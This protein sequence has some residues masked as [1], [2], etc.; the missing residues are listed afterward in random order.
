MPIQQ[1]TPRD[2]RAILREQQKCIVLY[3]MYCCHSHLS[4]FLLNNFAISIS[5]IFSHARESQP[6]T[7]DG[8]GRPRE[9]AYCYLMCFLHTLS[10]NF[11][12]LWSRF[13]CCNLLVNLGMCKLALYKLI[14]LRDNAYTGVYIC[15]RV[16]QMVINSQIFALDILPWILGVLAGLSDLYLKT[17]IIIFLKKI[18]MFNPWLDRAKI[19]FFRQF[20]ILFPRKIINFSSHMNLIKSHSQ[21]I[22]RRWI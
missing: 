5:S 15:A 18:F 19:S 8:W 16:V 22:L 6:R 13:C 17:T 2:S 3:C 10:T 11:M 1:T 14:G 20:V 21:G 9:W 12:I 7:D 4:A